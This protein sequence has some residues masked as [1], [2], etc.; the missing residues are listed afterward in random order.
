MKTAVVYFSLNGNCDYVAQEIKK[1]IGADLIRLE[2]VKPYPKNA[3]GLF[4]IGGGSAI[5]GD[6]PELK[7]YQFHGSDY[8]KVIII[9]P[10][11]AD[12]YVPAVNTFLAKHALS[13]KKLGFIMCSKGGTGEKFFD[14]LYATYGKDQLVATLSLIDPYR[15]K[16]EDNLEKI[17]SFCEAF[18]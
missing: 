4:F 9:S 18:A 1:Q 2:T 3:A 6:K 13:G 5:K 10:N 16:K 11:W 15:L 12:H 7:P 17:K 8:D 14:K